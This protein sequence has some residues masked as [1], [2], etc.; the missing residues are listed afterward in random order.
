MDGLIPRGSG[1]DW[2]KWLLGAC[3][4]LLL[5]AVLGIAGC[6]YLGKKAVEEVGEDVQR[7]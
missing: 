6:T 4:I 7:D 3:S 1:G 2:W 5:I